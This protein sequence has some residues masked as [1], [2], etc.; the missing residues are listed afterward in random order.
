MYKKETKS[1]TIIVVELLR[2]TQV[3]SQMD[4]EG[5]V[6]RRE[7]IDTEEEEYHSTYGYLLG[8]DM[9]KSLMRFPI[10]R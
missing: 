5:H 4:V 2:H 10:P 7:N 3:A 9:Q 8:T 6:D 1:I